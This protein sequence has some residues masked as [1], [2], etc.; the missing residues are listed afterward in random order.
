MGRRGP[1]PVKRTKT[2]RLPVLMGDQQSRRLR[3]MIKLGM[4]P[5]DATKFVRMAADEVMRRILTESNM[6]LLELDALVSEQARKGESGAE[7]VKRVHVPDS[8]D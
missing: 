7:S 1:E 5:M 3:L 2:D 6:T 4:I 8:D